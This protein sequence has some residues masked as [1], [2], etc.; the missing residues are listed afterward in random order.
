[1]SETLINVIS[2]IIS[3]I[4]VVAAGIM[5]VIGSGIILRVAVLMSRWALR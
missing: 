3:V 1:M 4:L 5:F 2:W